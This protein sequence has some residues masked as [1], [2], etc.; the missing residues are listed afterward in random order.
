MKTLQYIL[1][2]GVVL[3]LWSV[4]L[5]SWNL[6]WI[7]LIE[8]EEWWADE[9]FKYRNSAKLQSAFDHPDYDTWR[10]AWRGSLELL[11]PESIE[12]IV[13]RWETVSQF[14]NWLPWYFP[15]VVSNFVENDNLL[16]RPHKYTATKKSVTVHHTA[17]GRLYRLPSDSQPW[18]REIYR[19]HAVSQQWWDIGYNFLI[20]PQ[21]R[22]YEW[23][24]WGAWVVAWHANLWNS[25]TSLWVALLWN[26]EN[27]R[28]TSTA[29]QSL[30]NLTTLLT[31]Q[32]SINPSDSVQL[33]D[34]IIE[35]P[36]I[37]AHVHDE[38]IVWHKDIKS[39]ACPGE[40]LYSE[41]PWLVEEVWNRLNRLDTHIW[42]RTLTD[43]DFITMP[44]ALRSNDR[45]WWITVPWDETITS[46]SC[47]WFS[48]LTNGIVCTPVLW[49][50]RIELSYQPNS[51]GW[52]TVGIDTY[53]G[54]KLVSFSVVREQDIKNEVTGLKT[55]FEPW[56]PWLNQK[57]VDY[58]LKNQAKEYLEEDI[59]VLLYESTKSKEVTLWCNTWCEVVV[60]DGV[61]SNA[62][63]III[64]QEWEKIV[65]F[66]DL[67]RYDAD[68]I[69]VRDSGW[70][71]VQITNYDRYSW[72]LPLNTYKWSLSF[73]IQSWRDLDQW[74]SESF[75]VVNT[76]S[77]RDYLQWMGESSEAQHFEKTK[78]L[79]LLT[80]TYALF[81]RSWKNPHPSIPQWVSYTAIDDPRIFQRYV[82]AWI[83]SLSPYWLQAVDA[84][85]DT[86]VLYEDFVPILPY[87]HCSW[88]FSRSGQEKF[89]WTD[90]PWLTSKKDFVVCELGQFEWHGV[91]MSGDGAEYLAQAGAS[92]EDILQWWY[93]GVELT[94]F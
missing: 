31:Y 26:F 87:Y 45:V 11:D 40:Y 94:T 27:V 14:L 57:M 19:Q 32:Y 5:A 54:A 21:G 28:P 29:M 79:A 13:E 92:A 38:A 34:R 77:F 8:R 15:Q 18:L 93:S 49:W 60:D 61:I 88:W 76:L 80:K 64:R 3:N 85:Y 24:S 78:T 68:L 6:P 72:E 48:E 17:D 36:Y 63:T 30:T 91:W 65:W 39:T 53:R 12:E 43:D 22:I 89:W 71:V 37:E 4:T 33:F 55:E 82:W 16:S 84:T 9:S 70:W 23:R 47:E 1:V 51:S 44:R 25:I 74:F 69:V 35:S 50:V 86:L 81:Y 41:I 46:V 75:T 66:I 42:S 67:V 10:I 90:T 20:D 56:T 52:H 7:D 73:E 2:F 59:S 58:I 62:Q 83:E